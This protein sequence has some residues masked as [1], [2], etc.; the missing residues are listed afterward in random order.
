MKTIRVYTRTVSM[1][2]AEGWE[3]F[4]IRRSDEADMF[5]L[6]YVDYDENG[7]VRGRGTEDFSLER[8][9]SLKRHAYEIKKDSGERTATGRTKWDLVKTAA[10][11]IKKADYTKGTKFWKKQYEDNGMI[12]IP[13]R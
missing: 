6:E 11:R 9:K 8:L 2:T 1:H 5:E 10:I 12:V 4:S 13:I 7:N 3:K